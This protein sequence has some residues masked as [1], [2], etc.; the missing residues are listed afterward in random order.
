MARLLTR[1]VRF[2]FCYSLISLSLSLINGYFQ[3]TKRRKNQD[4]LLTSVPECT[5]SFV[6]LFYSREIE[7]VVDTVLFVT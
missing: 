1:L 3:C 2:D 5:R 6:F 7:P 4:C